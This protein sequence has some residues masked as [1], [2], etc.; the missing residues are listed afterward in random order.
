MERKQ[1]KHL[2]ILDSVK[3]FTQRNKTKCSEAFINPH[4]L[5]FMTATP[6]LQNPNQNWNIWIQ[7]WIFSFQNPFDCYEYR[8]DTLSAL[9]PQ[10]AYQTYGRADCE[11][12]V[13]SVQFSAN[14]LYDVQRVYILVLL[15]FA[16]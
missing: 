12:A 5:H 6:T 1:G 9:L 11:I 3:K 14:S 10:I 15:R 4:L 16:Q 7:N 13:N 2:C 8:E